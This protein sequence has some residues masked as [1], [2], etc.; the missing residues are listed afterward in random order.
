MVRPLQVFLIIFD[1]KIHA[2][3]WVVHYPLFIIEFK[4]VAKISKMVAKQYAYCYAI[5]GKNVKL[6]PI[7]DDYARR[8][9]ARGQEMGNNE[10]SWSA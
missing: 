7:M 6:R 9:F 8:K 5:T 2:D 1:L 4:N 10:F 3:G